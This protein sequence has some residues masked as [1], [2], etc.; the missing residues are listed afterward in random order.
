MKQKINLDG[1]ESNKFNKNTT[2]FNQ[3]VLKQLSAYL[4]QL[5]INPLIVDQEESE[6][7][8]CCCVLVVDD[9]E[10]KVLVHLLSNHI[11]FLVFLLPSKVH[12]HLTRNFLISFSKTCSLLHLS[13]VSTVHRLEYA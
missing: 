5:V 8:I 1:V 7:F 6:V 11:D 12:Q 10:G 2:L 4:L 3:Q 9:C 13:H